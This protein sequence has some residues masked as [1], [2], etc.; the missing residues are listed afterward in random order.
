MR[1]LYQTRGGVELGM[2]KNF[3]LWYDG[4]LYIAVGCN[5]LEVFFLFNLEAKENFPNIEVFYFKG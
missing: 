3:G 5:I 2:V 4:T 1:Y